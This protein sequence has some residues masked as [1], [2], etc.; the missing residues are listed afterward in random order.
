MSRKGAKAESDRS[1]RNKDFVKEGIQSR[2]RMTFGRVDNQTRGSWE[3]ECGETD[4]DGTGLTR[5]KRRR[6]KLVES[7]IPLHGFESAR[8]SYCE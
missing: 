6:R 7:P 5:S 4:G 3:D 2:Y 1:Q 8:N